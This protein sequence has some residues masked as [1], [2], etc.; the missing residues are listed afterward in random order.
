MANTEL[1]N[2]YISQGRLIRRAWVD[3]DE[4]GRKTACLL[5]ALSPDVCR[6]HDAGACP[7]DIMPQWLAYL[8]P[9]MDDDGTEE[10]WLFMVKRYAA[11]AGRW[12]VLSD[13]T[14]R[15]LDYT[16]RRIAVE[17]CLPL[18]GSAASAVECILA[19]LRLSE[20]GARVLGS[21]WDAA[22]AAA[23][24]GAD[25]VA[26]AAA[27]AAAR[28]AAWAIADAAAEAAGRATGAAWAVADAASAAAR[29]AAD[30]AGAAEAAAVDRITAAILTAIEQA[31]DAAEKE[32]NND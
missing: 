27:E 14:W 23:W 20:Q 7:A 12:H 31:C 5:A 32:Q 11:V 10:A 25:A 3:I 28:A 26:D 30:A 1:L 17:D 24:A 4:H 29:A 9:W 16:A 6:A 22:W 13:E 15:R 21:E 8:T 19:L 2:H 18:A